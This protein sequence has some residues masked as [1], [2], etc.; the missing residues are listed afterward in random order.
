MSGLRGIQWA[1]SMN[2]LSIWS[3]LIL[4]AIRFAR[5]NCFAL[6]IAY[7]FNRSIACL[8]TQ[9]PGMAPLTSL[10]PMLICLLID[11]SFFVPL[12][13]SVHPHVQ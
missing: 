12:T 6:Y 9:S 5:S 1:W 2:L 7:S 4:K 13:T 10:E 11:P 3:S 8:P